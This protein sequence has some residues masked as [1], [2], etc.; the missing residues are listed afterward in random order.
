M[1]KCSKCKRSNIADGR[2]PYATEYPSGDHWRR[3]PPAAGRG[4]QCIQPGTPICK[5]TP[6]LERCKNLKR[7]FRR[8]LVRLESP[9]TA[10]S[11][12]EDERWLYEN[13][14]L[15]H[16]ELHAT[17]ET[18]RSQ[19]KLPHVRTQKGETVPRALALAEEFL[20]AVSYQFSDEKFTFFVNALQQSTDVVLELQ[21]LWVFPA[22]LKLAL[23]EQ[24]AAG[25][26]QLSCGIRGE[27]ASTAWSV[28][29]LRDVAQVSWKEVIEPLILFDYVLHTDPAN[30][31]SQ[32]DFKSRDLYRNKLANIAPHSDLNELE[33]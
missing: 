4:M 29:S 5:G 20:E 22:A 7:R 30:C 6:F 31:Y 18:L 2:Y 33:G 11:V 3:S 23:L 19:R 13:I 26:N 27:K 21:E 8:L 15:L 1:R 28:R 9:P 16:T 32:M 17:T 14:R 25:G 24:I 12:S 10:S